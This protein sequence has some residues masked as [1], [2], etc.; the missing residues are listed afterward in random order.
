MGVI[1]WIIS[2]VVLAMVM[3]YK[4]GFLNKRGLAY[5]IPQLP[6]LDKAET[7][8][9]Y[10]NVLKFKIMSDWD[11]YI[12][13]RKDAIEIHLWKTENPDLPKNTGCYIRVNKSIDA[14]YAEYLPHNIMHEHGALEVKPWNM[15]QFSAL[16][17]SGNILH[18]GQQVT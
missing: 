1:I 5:A 2:L 3:A 6:Y 16:D 4:H 14:L 13:T 8:D 10:E 17:N 7:L 18:F 15:K 9:F 11:D 12:I